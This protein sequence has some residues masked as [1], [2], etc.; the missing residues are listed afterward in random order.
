MGLFSPNNLTRYAK[1]QGYDTSYSICLAGWTSHRALFIEGVTYDSVQSFNKEHSNALIKRCYEIL[2]WYKVCLRLKSAIMWDNLLVHERG[3]SLRHF[4]HI[5][6]ALHSHDLIALYI[7]SRQQSK[8]WFQRVGGNLRFS[9]SWT[10]WILS[11][12]VTVFC[13]G[14]A[15]LSVYYLKNSQYLKFVKVRL[16]SVNNLAWSSRMMSGWFMPQFG[17]KYARSV[18]DCSFINR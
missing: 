17:G 1:K 5:W 13:R 11:L 14:F 18:I 12:V 2:T 8:F 3:Y 7:I 9:K 4:G 15:F 6:V 16:Q 10:Q